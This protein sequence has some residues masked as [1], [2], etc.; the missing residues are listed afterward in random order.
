MQQIQKEYKY[1]TEKYN[2]ISTP[3]KAQSITI[4]TY[5]FEVQQNCKFIMACVPKKSNTKKWC[6]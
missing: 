6:R 2:Q 5:V 3:Q 1:I 4:V